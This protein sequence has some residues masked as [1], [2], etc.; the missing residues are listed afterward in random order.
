MGREISPGKAGRRKTGKA[1]PRPEDPDDKLV[2]RRITLHLPVP[3]TDVEFQQR[4]KALAAT[5]AELRAEVDRQDAVKAGLK[6]AKQEIVTRR[7]MLAEIVAR[8]E[9]PRD[10]AVDEIVDYRAGKVTRVRVDT[11]EEILTRPL[12]ESEQQIG[13]LGMLGD[14]RD[15]SAGDNHPWTRD[16]DGT[17]RMLAELD[18]LTEG[19]QVA[20][21]TDFQV[22]QV[23][24]W[25]AKVHATPPGVVWPDRPRFLPGARLEEEA[26]DGTE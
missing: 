2:R 25:V 1:G 23:D 6:E 19:P 4:A 3:L 21:W 11:G 26:A 13:M 10:V 22:Q 15:E 9:E 7:T 17:H 16:N 20:A 14:D 5:E 18:V 24:A 12:M 8:G